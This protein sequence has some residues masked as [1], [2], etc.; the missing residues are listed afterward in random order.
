MG[1]A[2]LISYCVIAFVGVLINQLGILEKPDFVYSDHILDIDNE[3]DAKKQFYM[4]LATTTT[5]NIGGNV[6]RLLQGT[7]DALEK[8]NRND[9]ALLAAAKRYPGASDVGAIK[10]SIGLYIDDPSTVDNPRWGIGWAV[11]L[12]SEEDAQNLQIQL[13]NLYEYDEPIRVIRLQT[14]PAPILRARIPWKNMF[15]P[16]IAPMLHW[17]RA[18]QQYENDGYQTKYEDHKEDGASSCCGGAI[19]MEVYVTGHNDSMEYIDYVV[20]MG[21]DTSRYIDEMFPTTST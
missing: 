9:E 6:G 17:G 4:I 1:R 10:L 7:N 12:S 3:G 2:F 18:F 20:L 5:S 11:A 15:T 16:M 21:D 13:Q 8:S 14:N 19:A